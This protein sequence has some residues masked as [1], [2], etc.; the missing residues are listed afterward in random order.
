MA[1][2]ERQHDQPIRRH[3][4]RVP[5]LPEEK[6]RIE[7]NARETGLSVAAFLREVGQG[8]QP[9]SVVDLDQVQE[10]VRINADMGRLGGLLKLWLTDDARMAR[11]STKAIVALLNRI[12][13]FRAEMTTIMRSVVMPRTKNR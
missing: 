1:F 10:M 8:Y 12:E 5:V 7:L 11:F 4:L 13:A 2:K 6:E 9:D 3:H